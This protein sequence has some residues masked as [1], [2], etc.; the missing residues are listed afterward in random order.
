MDSTVLLEQKQDLEA[1]AYE[2]LKAA[3]VKGIYPPGYQIS[4]ELVADQ[5]GMS[6]SPVRTAIKQLLTEGFLEKRLNRRVYVTFG[7]NI[8]TLN[9]LYVR[10]SLEGTAAYLAAINRTDNDIAE[11]E[12]LISKMDHCYETNDAFKLLQL[13]IEVHRIIYIA[14]KNDHLAR[15]G[16]NALEQEAIFSYH[17]LSNDSLRAAR[18]YQEHCAILN[19][20]IA[21]KADL[22]EQKARDHVDRLIER[23]QVQVSNQNNDKN[24]G[25]LLLAVH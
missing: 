14:A 25:S 10:K 13:G 8:R 2:Q 7:D 21:R 6:R 17:S 12:G 24:S 16:I 23:V 1:V 19:A 3:I 11:I 18:S 4:E 9:A 15:I 20:I 22:A 5:L